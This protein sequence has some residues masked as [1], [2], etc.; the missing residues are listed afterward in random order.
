MTEPL[1]AT[2]AR[3]LFG[4]VESVSQAA[5]ALSVDV[6]TARKWANGKTRVPAGV[7][8]E[9]AGLLQDREAELPRLRLAALVAAD[10]A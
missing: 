2:I 10:R 8:R 3:A 5:A 4:E 9:L 1:F 6:N 7:W